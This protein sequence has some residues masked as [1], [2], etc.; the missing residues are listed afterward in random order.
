MS[1]LYHFTDGAALVSI[2]KSDEFRA[3]EG[4]SI[5]HDYK[6]FVSTTRQQYAGVG[7][8]QAML[9]SD[10]CKLVLD[11]DKLNSRYKIVPVDWGHAKAQAIRDSWPEPEFSFDPHKA[12]RLKQINVESEDR[13]LLR[14]PTIPYAHRY[15][16]TIYIDTNTIDPGD[17][18]DIIKYGEKYGIDVIV[19]QTTKEFMMAH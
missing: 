12:E 9:A 14:K 5:N 6:Y 8:P 19:T 1:E 4:D 11:G 3:S 18:E 10:I 2:L 15:I 13:I 16:K 7:Y 17:A